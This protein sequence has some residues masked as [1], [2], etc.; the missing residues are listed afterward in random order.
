MSPPNPENDPVHKGLHQLGRQIDGGRR[1][2]RSGPAGRPLPTS[3]ATD[4]PVEKGLHELGRQIDE[5][6][7]AGGRGRRKATRAEGT[8][9]DTGPRPRRAQDGA[10][11][12]AP[13]PGSAARSLLVLVLI[14]GAAA[15]YGWYLNHEIHRIDLKNLTSAPVKGDDAGHREHPHDRLDRPLRAQGAEPR[16]RPVLPGRQRREQRRRDDP[17]PQPGQPLGVDPVHPARPLRARTP[18]PTAP[19]RSTPRS[20][21]DRTS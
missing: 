14:A 17:A 13:R 21:R 18:A 2:E 15:G 12:S 10:P 11:A 8:P 7:R 5:A 19:T 20:T 4:N 16:L 1:A 3:A 9:G 6:N